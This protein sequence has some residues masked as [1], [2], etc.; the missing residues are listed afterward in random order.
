MW[1]MGK[2][3]EKAANAEIRDPDRNS[4]VRYLMPSVRKRKLELPL[5]IGLH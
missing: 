4:Q 3:R 1:F 5:E 2:Q